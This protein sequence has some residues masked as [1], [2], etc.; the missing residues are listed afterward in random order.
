MKPERPNKTKTKIADLSPNM[1]IITLSINFLNIPMKRQR[2][3]ESIE[4]HNQTTYCLKATHCKYN[5][6]GKLKA[7]D[8]NRYA[9]I[10][11]RKAGVANSYLISDYVNF[12]AKKMTRDYE[13][14]YLM[15]KKVNLQKRYSNLKCVCTK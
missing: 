12:R 6:I 11:Q 13:E 9:S 4:K 2:L 7:K 10:S 5:N 3:A 1:S 8:R 15:I 14:H